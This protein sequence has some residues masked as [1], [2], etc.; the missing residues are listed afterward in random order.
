MLCTGIAYAVLSMLNKSICWI[1]GIVS[2][3]IL[4]YKDFTQYNL[5]FDGILQIFYVV[6]GITGLY[7][8]VRSANL[9]GSPKIFSLPFWSH[10]N[11]WIL[12]ALFSALLVILIQMFYNP[13]FAYLDSVTTVFSLWATWLLVNRIYENWY[14]WIVINVAYI[15]IYQ[16]QGGTLAAVLYIIYLGT[17]IGG[18]IAWRKARH[19][20]EVIGSSVESLG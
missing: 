15:Y 10:I 12:G 6:L 20:P 18:L 11:A 2:C 13:A 7:Q 9:H 16:A 4:S 14:Y 8:W 17:A 3:A 19:I 5:Y 1:F